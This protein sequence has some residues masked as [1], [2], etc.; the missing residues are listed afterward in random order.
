MVGNTC[1]AQV[2]V[3]E[4]FSSLSDILFQA[5]F[6][7]E[8]SLISTLIAPACGKISILNCFEAFQLLFIRGECANIAVG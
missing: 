5:V 8:Q 7:R 2:L 4:S 3:F 1:Y 6:D